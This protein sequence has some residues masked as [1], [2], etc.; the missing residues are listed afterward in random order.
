MNFFKVFRK[1]ESIDRKCIFITGAPRSGT[2]MITKVIDTHPDVAI[3]MENIFQNR[4][5]HWTK[6]DFWNSQQ[7]LKVEVDKVFSKF[8]EPIIGNK[9][10]TP[11]VWSADDIHFFCQ[12]FQDFKIVFILRDPVQVLLSRFR[13]EDYSAEFNAVAKKNILLDFRSKFLT[14]TSS[15]RQSVE[16]YWK[17][18]D[19]NPTQIYL[20]YYDDFSQNFGEEAQRLFKFLNLPFEDK[21]LNWHEYPHHNH[22]GNIVRDLKYKDNPIKLKRS[23][24]QNVADEI[25]EQIKDAVISIEVHHNLWKNRL[26]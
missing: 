21:I 9:V 10:C 14:Y 1:K 4:R 22:D 12:I 8:N 26:I 11:D 7:K 2:S 19:G 24:R 5:R 18:R 6:A 23:T 17:L 20:V 15:W 13:R 3:L 16:N 25:Y